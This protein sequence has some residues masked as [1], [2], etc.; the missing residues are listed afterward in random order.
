MPLDERRQRQAA[1][2]KVL[3]ANDL[4][5]WAARFLGALERPRNVGSERAQFRTANAR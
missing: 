2:F 3:A 4:S 5:N 1:N